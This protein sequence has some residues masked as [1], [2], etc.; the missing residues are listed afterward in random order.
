[1]WKQTGCER[2]HWLRRRET[3]HE[4]L[5]TGHPETERLGIRTTE[6]WRSGAKSGRK[7]IANLINIVF[8]LIALA[9]LWLVCKTS[10]ITSAYLI[11]RT[12]QQHNTAYI[13]VKVCL[14]KFAV[15]KSKPPQQSSIHDQRNHC[16]SPI[17]Q[18]YLRWNNI[19]KLNEGAWNF[20]LQIVSTTYSFQ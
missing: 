5:H 11:T 6:L 9:A 3:N 14:L 20:T 15:S 17:L 16:K 18:E 10:P 12:K 8:D 13:L 4:T 2:Y 1:V 7:S 19:I